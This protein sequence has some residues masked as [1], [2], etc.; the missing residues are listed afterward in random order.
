MLSAVFAGRDA[1]KPT[2]SH[3]GA[4]PVDDAFGIL[5]AL[6][7][8]V[9]TRPAPRGHHQEHRAVQQN[10]RM[11][12]AKHGTVLLNGTRVPT[13]TVGGASSST[14]TGGGSC[15]TLRSS[16]RAATPT[17]NSSA[18]V[19]ASSA[20]DGRE[21]GGRAGGRDCVNVYHAGLAHAFQEA[22]NTGF[23]PPHEKFHTLCFEGRQQYF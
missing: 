4:N 20:T 22:K 2:S 7:H 13:E 10:E 9:T 21:T 14:A 16:P 5:G 11:G 19:A 18:S 1:S 8:L 15:S 12:S 23:Y 6:T 3:G 17:E